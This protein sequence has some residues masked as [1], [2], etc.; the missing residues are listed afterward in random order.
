[1]NSKNIVDD[2]KVKEIIKESY[3]II[4][5]YDSKEIST[6]DDA[7]EKMITAIVE[8]TKNDN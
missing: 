6:K 4:K 7:V 5:M 8:V 1:M 3:K 2:K